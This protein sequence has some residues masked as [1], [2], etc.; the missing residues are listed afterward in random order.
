MVALVTAP[1]LGPGRLR[2][3]RLLAPSATEDA[4]VAASTFVHEFEATYGAQ[5]PR[6]L[7]CAYRDALQRAQQESKFLLLYLH[8]AHHTARGAPRWA[9]QRPR[10]ARSVRV[11]R[12]HFDAE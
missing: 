9:P 4:A 3:P 6:F 1:L 5:H 2:V 8:A 7:H 11:S 10:A 12:H